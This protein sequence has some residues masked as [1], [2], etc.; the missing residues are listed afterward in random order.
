MKIFLDGNFGPV[1]CK[2]EICWCV[3]VE[4]GEEIEGTRFLQTATKIDCNNL[5][6]KSSLRSC[7]Q[8]EC[9]KKKQCAYGFEKDTLGCSLCECV[10]PCKVNIYKKIL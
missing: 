1:Q 7:S 3:N 6:E 2:N 8:A 5:A 10:N 4:S 9:H